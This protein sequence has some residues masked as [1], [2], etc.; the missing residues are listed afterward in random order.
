MRL[1]EA[2]FSDLDELRSAVR[3]WDLDF[4]PLSEAVGGGGVGHVVETMCGHVQIGAG[5]FTASIEQWGAPPAGRL[6]FVVP[7]VRLKRVW[8]R[9]R[10][11]D[12]GTVLVFPIGSELHSIS[13]PDFEVHTIAV[14][15]ETV[16][17]ICESYGLHL[18][19]PSRRAEAFRL[20]PKDLDACRVALRTIRD[21]VQ[22]ASSLDA[23]R[24]LELLVRA[25]A[26][27]GNV[28][29]R[30]QASLRSRDRAVR[31]CIELL[32]GQD[33][34]A[35]STSDLCAIA[36][37]SER[38]LQ[39]AFRERFGLTPAAFIKA[40]RMVNVRRM[41]AKPDSHDV[42]V[43]DAMANFG[44]WHVGQ[45]ATDYRAAFGETPSATLKRAILDGG[46]A[47]G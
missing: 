4:Y 13:G 44:F 22:T 7:E 23:W 9:G 25:W 17:Q 45:F 36:G 1:I 39:Y 3:S 6:T 46:G 42:R 15:E 20:S 30:A 26:Q 18:P 38:T 8:W 2:T 41:L 24:V 10:D 12:Q 33:W 27:W 5:R 40:R 32:Q 34:W 29:P 47:T 14:D 11:V 19:P 35:L 28:L 37:V 43:G 16:G 31:T 21:D